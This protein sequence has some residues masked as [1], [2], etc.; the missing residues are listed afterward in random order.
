M[1]MERAVITFKPSDLTTALEAAKYLDVH[2]T[3]IYR[4]IKDETLHPIYIAGQN[5][6]SI[7][8]VKNLK[9]RRE[10]EASQR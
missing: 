6:L 9:K 5:Y 10:R 1:S 7:S 2:F 8:E 4:W 3:T